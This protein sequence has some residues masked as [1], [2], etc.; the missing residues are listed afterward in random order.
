LQPW[1]DGMRNL[2]FLLRKRIGIRRRTVVPDA[3]SAQSG[4]AE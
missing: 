2:L 3:G 4:G 1:K